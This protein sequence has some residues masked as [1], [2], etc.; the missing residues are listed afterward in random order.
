MTTF[1]ETQV[2]YPDSQENVEVPPDTLIN[3]GFIPKQIGVRGQP[4]PAN[5][6][7]WLFR[8]VFRKVNRDRISDGNGVGVIKSTDIDCFVTVHAMVKGD[9]T[10]WLSAIGY[11]T[12]TGVPVMKV[13]SSG[14]LT[15][16]TLTATD[17]PI[18][19]A[20]ASTIALRV[21]ITDTQ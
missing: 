13:T 16:G 19:G 4:L 9:N 14:V 17:I 3:N 15:L 8:E 18:S 12:G 10:K 21:T 6:L 7:N 2:V 5:W 1:A 11:K 20:T